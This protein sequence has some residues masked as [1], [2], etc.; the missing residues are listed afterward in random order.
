ML[1]SLA[2]VSERN[3]ERVLAVRC[4][5]DRTA[6]V[7]RDDNAKR[8]VRSDCE[9]ES[10]KGKE[11]H[12][13]ADGSKRGKKRRERERKGAKKERKKTKGYV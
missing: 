2:R 13:C 10:Y 3:A 1:G 7:Q 8:R 4:K 6:V 5:L 11:S 12:P 9:G